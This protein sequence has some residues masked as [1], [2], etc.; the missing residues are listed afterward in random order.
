MKKEVNN[1]IWI[2][3]IQSP[4]ALLIVAHPDDET[5]FAGGLILT[6]IDTDW[7]II[8]C[9]IEK[10]EREEEFQCAC[11]FLE[12]KSNN[13]IT[14]IVLSHGTPKTEEKLC[15]ELRKITN[16]YD[17]VF[18]HN[19][20]G[21]YEGQYDPNHHHIMVHRCVV[22][23]IAHPNT[24]LFISRGSW[25]VDQDEFMYDSLSG[26]KWIDIPFKILNLKKKIFHQCHVSQAKCY[27]YDEKTGMLRETA[28][29]STL[30][31]SFNAGS[32]EYTFFSKG[33][34]DRFFRPQGLDG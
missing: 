5:I 14:P 7:T 8:A 9:I 26:K 29:K 18:T 23:T 6:S 10:P 4:R 31:W 22:N 2:S 3:E 12:E 19:Y 20:K 32:E 34:Y 16:G 27:G 15:N 13:R 30:N 11:N 17:I 1:P 33:I 24:W 21:E 25:N 28:L